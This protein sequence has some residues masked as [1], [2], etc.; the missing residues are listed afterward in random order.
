[1]FSDIFRKSCRMWDSVEK[2]SGV[3]TSHRYQYNKAHAL[4]ML[5]NKAY[6]H[7]HLTLIAFPRQQSSRECASM[8]LY[9]YFASL[10]IYVKHSRYRPGVAQRVPGS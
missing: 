1:M 5:D 9:T 6:R 7:K 10:V 4:F 3:G 8:L 2:Y